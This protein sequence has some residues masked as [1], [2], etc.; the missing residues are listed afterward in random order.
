[1]VSGVVKGVTGVVMVS[2]VVKGLVLESNEVVVGSMVI[3]V[4]IGV[5][6]V[7]HGVVDV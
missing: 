3:E 2:V 1:M 7:V 4:V 6:K 5:V